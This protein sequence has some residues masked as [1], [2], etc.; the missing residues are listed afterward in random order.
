[1]GTCIEEARKNR[2]A[3]YWRDSVAVLEEDMAEKGHLKRVQVAGNRMQEL[4]VVVC[5]MKMK[6]KVGVVN[7]YGDYGT[8]RPS[9]HVS[10]IRVHKK[11]YIVN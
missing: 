7:S 6:T 2:N 3:S 5:P 11:L 8:D 10:L 9:D 1:V 4:A